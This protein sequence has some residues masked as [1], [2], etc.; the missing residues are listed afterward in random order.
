MRNSNHK[1]F[2]VKTLFYYSILVAAVLAFFIFQYIRLG[3]LPVQYL[4]LLTIALLCVY[5]ISHILMTR[6]TAGKFQKTIGFILALF[7]AIVSG[8]GSFYLDA[9]YDSLSM[10][11]ESSSKTKKITSIY[12][13]KSG[14]IENV[15][16]L[17]NHTIGIMENFEDSKGASAISKKLY[18]KK[19]DVK[20]KKY[21]S[22]IKMIK[23]LKGQ[24]I[25]GIIVDSSF[26]ATIED[27]EEEKDI[28]EKLVS[29]FDYEYYVEKSEASK[30]EV[31]LTSNPFSVFISGIDTYGQIEATSRSDVNMIATVNPKTHNVLLISIPRDYYVETK[32]EEGAGCAQGKLDKLTHTGLHGVETTEMTLENLFD[33]KINYNARVNFSSVVNIVNELGGVD[34]INPNT[35]TI[36]GYTFEAS[37]DPIHL[38]GD[39]ALAF[40]RE[41]YGFLEGD[42]ER[43]RNQMRVMNGIIK[44]ITSPQILKNFSGIM[45]AVGSSF[46][47]NMTVKEMTAL[48]NMQLAEGGSWRIYSCSVNGTGG[49]DFAYELGDNAYVMY[50]DQETITKAKENIDAI[51][52]G[53]IPPYA[54]A[55]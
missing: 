2:Y 18:N 35:F 54:Q 31:D 55:N 13:L 22:G 20:Y 32:C 24:A 48:V 5:L 19:I 17:K 49:T 6:S 26:I 36:G 10:M 53:D 34:V 28:R 4:V 3:I 44:K 51:V 33:M 41:R 50:P 37:P 14:A 45:K 46:Q 42:R 1:P 47:T 25:D 9:T 38:D 43:G 27:F 8:V 7:I 12:V 15:N 52:H 29:I 40:C 21:E 23:D 11:S 39:Q 30:D 16:D